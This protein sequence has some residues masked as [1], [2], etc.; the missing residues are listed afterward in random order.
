MAEGT[1]RVPKPNEFVLPEHQAYAGVYHETAK[2]AEYLLTKLEP[3]D[4]E[5]LDANDRA[6][7]I[8]REEF[9]ASDDFRL[10]HA[11]VKMICGHIFGGR[12]IQNWLDPLCYWATPETGQKSGHEIARDLRKW[13][14][15]SCPTCR[16]VFFPMVFLEPME[17]LGARLWFWDFAYAH[18]G[19]ARSALEEHSRKYLWRYVKYCRLLNGMEIV[20]E[21]ELTLMGYAQKFLLQFVTKLKSQALTPVQEDLREKL[22][23]L[24]E[25]DLRD[26][27]IF[28]QGDDYSLVSSVIALEGESEW[29]SEPTDATTS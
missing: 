5:T 24:A 26:D 19:V 29:E 16:R 15:T 20:G 27:P 3:V 25:F 1:T 28:T 11:P 8:C 4:V 9:H 10:A 12:C 2:I 6:C 17:L 21:S 14:N 22:Q 13:G 18:A 23:W 7:T